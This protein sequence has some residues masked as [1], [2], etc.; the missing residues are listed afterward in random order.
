MLAALRPCRSILARR[1]LAA[2]SALTAPPCARPGCR[3]PYS[4][5]TSTA[6][7][8]CRTHARSTAARCCSRVP[9][10]SPARLPTRTSRTAAAPH[11]RPRERRVPAAVRQTH[12]GRAHQFPGRGAGH[13]APQAAARAGDCEPEHAHVWLINVRPGPDPRERGDVNGLH[14]PTALN[15]RW[16]GV[17]AGRMRADRARRQPSTG[18]RT[19][20]PRCRNGA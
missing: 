1:G 20:L 14:T 10:A 15:R 12:H 2:S 11:A 19:Y 3:W 8:W 16:V 13:H 17:A 6:P 5:S 7:A 9:V 4:L 18:L